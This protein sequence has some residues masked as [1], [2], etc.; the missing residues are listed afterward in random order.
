M[1]RQRGF[2]LVELLAVMAIIGI[3]AGD[4]GMKKWLPEQRLSYGKGYFRGN[5]YTVTAECYVWLSGVKSR[6]FGKG[7]R[8][9]VATK[10][11]GFGVTKRTWV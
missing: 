5:H 1:R 7:V 6:C 8:C 10:A 4:I 11:L 3:L 9:G 2:T